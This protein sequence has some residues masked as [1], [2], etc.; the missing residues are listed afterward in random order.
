MAR[1]GG[2][3]GAQ[4]AGTVGYL[5]A[6]QLCLEQG[7][8]GLEPCSVTRRGEQIWRPHILT[9]STA[10]R[11]GSWMWHV[12]SGAGLLAPCCLWRRFPSLSLNVPPLVVAAWSHQ[13]SS[14]PPLTPCKPEGK[15]SCA[16]GLPGPLPVLAGGT[17]QGRCQACLKPAKVAWRY[18]VASQ[19]AGSR[20]TQA[21][22]AGKGRTQHG[23]SG[24]PLVHGSQAPTHCPHANDCTLL[25]QNCS[26]CG[27]CIEWES[28]AQTDPGLPCGD[29]PAAASD[30]LAGIP[31]AQRLSLPIPVP[32][33]HPYFPPCH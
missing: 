11:R 27:S 14:V 29:S 7:P 18:L 19:T 4:P 2:R 23:Q 33:L 30:P 22:G 25:M 28:P 12:G 15:S 24:E 17:V 9:I 21:S 26:H 10:S 16:L 3:A 13:T 6:A 8:K 20:Q 1:G 5:N 32:L 31:L